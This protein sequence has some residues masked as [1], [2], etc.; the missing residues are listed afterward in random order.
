MKTM[1]LII[2]LLLMASTSFAG[3]DTS[4]TRICADGKYKLTIKREG[5]FFGKNWIT[6]EEDKFFGSKLINETYDKDWS[7]EGETAVEKLAK[8]ELPCSNDDFY[9]MLKSQNTN[10]IE[11][12]TS[13]TYCESKG[14]RSRIYVQLKKTNLI[15]KFDVETQCKSKE[16]F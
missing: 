16:G 14:E 2:S 3:Y 5:S 15:L 1:A 9:Q 8:K 4:S 13:G 11:S 10:V 6:L 12:Y 7:P